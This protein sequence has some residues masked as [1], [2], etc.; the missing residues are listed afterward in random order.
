MNQSKYTSR[1]LFEFKISIS[2]KTDYNL[3]FFSVVVHVYMYFRT[4]KFL[5]GGRKQSVEQRR[6]ILITIVKKKRH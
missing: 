5:D 2:F 1:Y 3:S 4:F 6:Y